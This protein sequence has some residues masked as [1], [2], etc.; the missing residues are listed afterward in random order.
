MR[1][2]ILAMLKL[3][4]AQSVF[5]APPADFG[6]SQYVDQAGCVFRL[7][8]GVW[9]AILDGTGQPI[10]GFPPTFTG[11]ANREQ[12]PKDAGDI[13]A[14]KLASGL[15]QGEFI[16]DPR[17]MEAPGMAASHGEDRAILTSIAAQAQYA[18][19]PSASLGP[20]QPA[21]CEALGY[22]PSS[23]GR[24]RLGQDVTLGLCAGM[25][26]EQPRA[27]SSSSRKREPKKAAQ[28]A[29]PDK[30]AQVS[31]SLVRDERTDMSAP[32]ARKPPVSAKQQANTEPAR[33]D[34][35]SELIPASA[36]F[37]QVAAYLDDQNADIVLRRLSGMG[38][39]VAQKRLQQEGR[40]IRLVFAG[41]YTNRR[42]LI[43]ALNDLRANGY[44]KAVAR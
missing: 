32:V 29:P 34:P 10:C 36:R 31:A 2:M 33:Q 30:P 23:D 19:S 22:K 13:L 40:M 8:S 42:D 4:V 39:R 25:I 16:G 27:A 35:Q 5:A 44:P 17:P 11:N 12:Q 26:V 3:A 28:N 7:D 21:L 1:L 18:V 6:G 43:K 41:P 14:Q 20:D 37:V 38:Y 9:H 15:R 24:P